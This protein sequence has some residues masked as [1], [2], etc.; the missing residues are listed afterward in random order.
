[1]PTDTRGGGPKD[2]KVTYQLVAVLDAFLNELEEA[3]KYGADK[4]NNKGKPE[5]LSISDL[6]NQLINIDRST[7]LRIVRDLEQRNYIKSADEA[8]ATSSRHPGIKY[9]ELT[10]DGRAEALKAIHKYICNQG[11]QRRRVLRRRRTGQKRQ[12]T[13]ARQSKDPALA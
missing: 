9:Y 1:M 12:A 11:I 4:K 13:Q 5:A 2:R 3:R 8:G 7:I 6:A 10:K